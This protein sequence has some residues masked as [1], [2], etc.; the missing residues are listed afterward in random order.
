MNEKELPEKLVFRLTR[1][2]ITEAKKRVEKKRD[3]HWSVHLVETVAYF[4]GKPSGG[5]MPQKEAEELIGRLAPRDAD[6]ILVRLEKEI[7]LFIKKGYRP[8]II[9][10]PLEGWEVEN[11]S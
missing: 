2:R 9:K 1:K 3:E 7:R 6:R 4:L 11:G 8:K 10:I 5:Y